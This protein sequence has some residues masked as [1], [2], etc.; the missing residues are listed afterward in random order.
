MSLAIVIL[1]L[2]LIGC[3]DLTTPVGKVNLDQNS[4]DYKTVIV[5]QDSKTIYEISPGESYCFDLADKNVY[6][7][8]GNEFVVLP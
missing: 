2:F 7:F 8:D 6:I 3:A 1:N 4:L 5:S